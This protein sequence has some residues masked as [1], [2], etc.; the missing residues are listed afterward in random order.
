MYCLLIPPVDHDAAAFTEKPV[1]AGTL[2]EVT[3][4][5][6]KAVERTGKE[7]RV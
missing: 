6:R 5:M 2:L 7:A 3:V 4:I 1:E